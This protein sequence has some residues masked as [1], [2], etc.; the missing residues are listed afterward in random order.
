MTLDLITYNTTH[1]TLSILSVLKNFLMPLVA[2]AFGAFVGGWFAQRN[3]IKNDFK[4]SMQYL[5]YTNSILL[6]LVNS[7]YGF[8]KQFIASENITQEMQILENIKNEFMDEYLQNN[9]L[10]SIKEKFNQFNWLNK[11]IIQSKYVLPLNEEKLI[12]L[13]KVNINIYTLILGCKETL[14][15]LNNLI[16][17]LNLHMKLP[18]IDL[19]KYLKPSCGFYQKLYELRIALHTNIDDSINNI[20]LLMECINKAGSI[21]CKNDKNYFKT[22]LIDNIPENLKPTTESLYPELVKWINE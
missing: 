14:E 9:D 11:K 18:E 17:Q 12:I 5:N 8:K 1:E 19:V 7:L 2:A 10:K 15:T 6:A 20:V 16:E 3:K 22:T 4:I 13:S 21:L